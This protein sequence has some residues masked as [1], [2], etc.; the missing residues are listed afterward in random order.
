MSLKKAYTDFIQA[1]NIKGSNKALSYIRALDLL[2]KILKRSPLFNLSDFWS[3]SSIEKIGFLYEYALSFQ[4]KEGSVF[5][6]KDLPPSYGRN[7]YYSAAL[8]SYRQF[9]I[10]HQY[11]DQLWKIYR[12]PK[13]APKELSRLLVAQKA[14]SIEHL[15]SDKGI[16]LE[17]R[18]GR[19]VL[20]TE[21]ARLG[22]GFF[23]KMIMSQYQTRC[24]ITGLNIPEVL[25]A[26]HITGWA[27]D[28]QNRMNPCNGLCLSATYD[29]AF[30]R[31]LISFDEDYRMVL[32]P[33]LKEY[34]TNKAFKDYFLSREGDVISQPVR[35]FPDKTLLE[36]H[37]QK[38]AS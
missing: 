6:Q 16:D 35:Y 4:K 13:I 33:S 28:P 32:S 23:R 7:G 19:D 12:N 34:Y 15:V 27:E 36:K 37:R 30:D 2:D 10:V 14:E 26:S 18:E 20:R 21:K 31:H 9:L 29:A 1:E 11:E 17:S 3:I 8:K 22:Q 5:L 38:M 24:C 25:R